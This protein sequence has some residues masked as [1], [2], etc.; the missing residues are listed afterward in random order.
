MPFQNKQFDIILNILSP[1]NYVEFNRLLKDDG[2]VIKIVPQTD[3]LKELREI[4][5]DEPEKQAY[6]NADTVDLFKEN[7]QMVSTSRIQYTVKLDNPLIHALVR[8]TPLTWAASEE[9]LKE[10]LE[11]ESAELTVDLEI[12][13]GKKLN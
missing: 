13:I 3:Y 10:F 2:L 6:S 5:Y 1:S 8:M 4:V 11:S 7:F 12:L 9:K